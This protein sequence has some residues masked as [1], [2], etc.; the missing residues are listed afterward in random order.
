MIAQW[1]TTTPALICR[2][3]VFGSPPCAP[4]GQS[5][6]TNCIS[7]LP[8]NQTTSSTETQNQALRLRRATAIRFWRGHHDRQA[9]HMDAMPRMLSSWTPL[10]L[11]GRLRYSILG[12]CQSGGLCR[13]VRRLQLTPRA[14]CSGARCDDGGEAGRFWISLLRLTRDRTVGNLSLLL[15]PGICSDYPRGV[16]TCHK[17]DKDAPFSKTS[18]T[19][20]S[21]ACFSKASV[22]EP[23]KT[24]TVAP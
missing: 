19:P 24:I 6:T 4:V 3:P 8:R 13:Y 9:R 22:R 21:W 12:Y 17:A 15:I 2:S 7:V 14:I 16:R 5:W 1:T 20:S 18:V 11:V 23:V 10:C